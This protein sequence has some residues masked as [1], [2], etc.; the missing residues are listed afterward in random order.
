MSYAELWLSELG[1]VVPE[2]HDG[3]Q[4]RPPRRATE[5]AWPP[6]RRRAREDT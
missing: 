5:L 1:A 3:E 4:A 6:E 2:H